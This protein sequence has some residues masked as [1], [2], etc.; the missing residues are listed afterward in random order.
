MNKLIF[1][2]ALFACQMGVKAQDLS[3]VGMDACRNV[4]YNL[5]YDKFMCQV[6]A[7]TNTYHQ[8][9]PCT[10]LFPNDNGFRFVDPVSFAMYGEGT[11]GA[12]QMQMWE[13]HIDESKA[14]SKK[15]YAD[16]YGCTLQD[17]GSIVQDGEHVATVSGGTD[18]SVIRSRMQYLF[19]N[20]MV[21][22]SYKPGKRYYKT[23]GNNFVRIEDGG[24][25][26]SG[27]WQD[28][29]GKSIAVKSEEMFRDA[30]PVK[31]LDEPICPTYK[32]VATTLSE[33]AEFSEFFGLLKACA[34]SVANNK[35][36][37]RSAD[38]KYGNMFVLKNRGAV[39]AEDITQQTKAVYLLGDYNYTLYVPTNEAMQQAYA[40]GLP[41]LKDLEEAEEYDNEKDLDSS[42]S[43]DSH[44]AKILEVMLDFVRY[45]IQDH[46]VFVDEGFES[47]SYRSGKLMH[48]TN[49]A[50]NDAVGVPFPLKVKVSANGLSV[51]DC[52][53]G[54]DK[55][56]GWTGNTANVVMTKG[57]YNLMANE[58]WI[59]SS[60]AVRNPYT[61]NI[62]TAPFVVIHAID[63]PLIYS[64][65]KHNGAD[66]TVLPTQFEYHY[67]NNSSEQ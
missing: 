52:R 5:T 34:L 67:Y 37:W 50:G 28:A 27:P 1:S 2:M 7:F 11:E 26:V 25:T 23:R 32:N 10:A 17:D 38:Q 63:A 6:D 31:E 15:L 58:I 30:C 39:G 16:V 19:D 54:Y 18:N 21:T 4:V 33:H 57:L 56:T 47:G 61:C 36:R 41:T 55:G 45:H 44:A 24:M 60:T 42:V 51:T 14:Y 43:P 3:G 12:R 46:A 65:G 49:A 64:D 62:A 35:D 13:M 66:G 48:Y 59:S 40:M 9:L 20:S 29:L 53:D 22:E 8:I